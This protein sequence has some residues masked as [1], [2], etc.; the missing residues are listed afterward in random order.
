MTFQCLVIWSYENTNCVE[1]I[2]V[3]CQQTPTMHNRACKS[4]PSENVILHHIKPYPWIIWYCKVVKSKWHAHILKCM[5]GYTCLWGQTLYLEWCVCLCTVE[6]DA[7]VP[8]GLRRSRRKRLPPL[9]WFRGERPKYK[10]RES[11]IVQ[12]PPTQAMII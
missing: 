7:D 5:T 6:P 9:A 2:M 10:R 3:L 4:Q 1:E 12:L 8:E 11:G